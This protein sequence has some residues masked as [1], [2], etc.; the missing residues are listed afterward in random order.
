MCDS[1]SFEIPLSNLTQ[2]VWHNAER[3]LYKKNLINS[4]NYETSFFL[5]EF[6]I[7]SN[8]IISFKL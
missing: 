7:P 2:I 1:K 5:F 6:G 8:L 3:L 4:M